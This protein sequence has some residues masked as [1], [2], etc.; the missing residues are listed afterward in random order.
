MVCYVRYVTIQGI[1]FFVNF[2][3]DLFCNML[4]IK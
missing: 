4:I 2:T 1:C 3:A